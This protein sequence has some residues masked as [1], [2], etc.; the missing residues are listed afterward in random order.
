MNEKDKASEDKLAIK[1]LQNFYVNSTISNLPELIEE[2]KVDLL[3]KFN[4]YMENNLKTQ[5]TKDGKP[6]KVLNVNPII[7]NKYFFSS[8][9]PLSGYQPTYSVETLGLVFGL[10]E[11]ICSKVNEKIGNYIP[12]LSNFCKFAGI[13]TN[14]FKNYGESADLE[15][16]TLIDKIEDYCFDTSVTAS[17]LG[18]AKESITKYRMK[19][20]IG[21]IEKEAPTIHFHQE[22]KINLKDVEDRLDSLI[23]YNRKKVVEA[24][25]TEK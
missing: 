6:Y 12:T 2:R 4:S 1:E 21:K 7:I 9:S 15:M 11:D 19:T 8:L 17:Q 14:T 25:F 3:D 22:N 23:N 20:E 13:S 16:R 10:Y 24:E 18:M 5:Y